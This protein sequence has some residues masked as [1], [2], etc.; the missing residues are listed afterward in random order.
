MTKQPVSFKTGC[1]ALCALY[2]ILEFA[3]AL[4]IP[5]RHFL[6]SSISTVSPFMMARL[7]GS[8]T[9]SSAS[10]IFLQA[11]SISGKLRCIG[12]LDSSNTGLVSPRTVY[13][14]FILYL[15]STLFKFVNKEFSRGITHY[16]II[17][18]SI[19]MTISRKCLFGLHTY[20]TC[21]FY[22]NEIH[23][24]TVSRTVSSS[25]TCKSVFDE[26]SLPSL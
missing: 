11:L 1:S 17:T 4:A 7:Q 12:R 8:S 26:T 24:L 9:G 10:A 22:L 18:G 25:P 23:I 5:S 16:L 2:R 3:L 13:I 21:I 15:D 20:S 6:R 14:N 19:G